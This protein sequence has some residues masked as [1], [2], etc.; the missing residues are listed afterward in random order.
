VPVSRWLRSIQGWDYKVD[1]DDD[2][3]EPPVPAGLQTLSLQLERFADFLG[4]DLDLIAAADGVQEELNFNQWLEG[5]IFEPLKH[6][7]YF[8]ILGRTNTAA[9]WIFIAGTNVCWTFSPTVKQPKTLPFVCR[10]ED[11][12]ARKSM[13]KILRVSN[14]QHR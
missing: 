2:E 12:T 8:F 4:I 5:P 11:A 1:T 6:R 9:L 14:P 3:V 13:Q 10:F 7:E